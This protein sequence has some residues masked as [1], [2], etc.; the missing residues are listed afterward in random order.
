MSILR[1][2]S[3]NDY[4]QINAALQHI[5]VGDLGKTQSTLLV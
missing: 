3:E 5:A 4:I 1:G 2:G